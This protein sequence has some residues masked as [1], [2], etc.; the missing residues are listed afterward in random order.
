MPIIL[1]KADLVC[2]CSLGATVNHKA[3]LANGDDFGGQVSSMSNVWRRESF[4]V[5]H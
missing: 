3:N 4:G 2:Q 5:R 1:S